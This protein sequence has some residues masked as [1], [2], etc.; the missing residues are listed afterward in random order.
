MT[1][2]A[3]LAALSA[4]LLTPGPTNTLLAL[5]GAERGWHA[6]LRLVPL[7]IAAYLAV[8]L[9]LAVAGVALEAHLPALRPLL[10]GGAGVWVM[11]L[12]ARMWQLP[13]AGSA[14]SVSGGR[15]FL[16]TLLNPKGLVIGLVLL[17][18]TQLGLRV[19]ALA[20]LIGLVAAFWAALGALLTGGTSGP[21]PRGAAIF[22]RLAAVWLGVLSLGLIYSAA[23][24][25]L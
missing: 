15:V 12:A 21:A 3:M 9:P 22:R 18:G 6:A 24:A 11:V 5:A 8:A 19:L 10:A 20:V 25:A 14:P 16:T 23:H 4:L 13:A 17:P 7:E 1:F 2:T